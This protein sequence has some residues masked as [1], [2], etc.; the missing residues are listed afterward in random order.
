VALAV[1]AAEVRAEEVFVLQNGVVLR[2]RVARETEERVVIRLAGFAEENTVTVRKR[3][4][5]RRFTSRGT[6]SAAPA[7]PLPPL[8]SGY[9][10]P[11]SGGESWTAT[12]TP[13]P[14]SAPPAPPTPTVFDEPAPTAEP[15]L[16]SEGFF[17]RLKRVT[18]LALPKSFEGLLLV[19]FLVFVVLTVLVAGGTRAL[20]M[21]A[22]SLHA[23]S[24]LGLLLGIFLAADFLLHGEILRA[25]RALW[26][27]PLQAGVWL[28]VA[29]T[30]LDAPLSK[31]V[32][33]FA[34]VLFGSTCFMFFT[35]SVL[36][37]V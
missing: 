14:G 3:E 22:P 35:G 27:L 30:A 6:G 28:F 7:D 20:G 31:T 11:P 25:D 24:S 37:S 19:A 10:L 16:Q 17:E 23:S 13:G 21:K 18:G 8:P 36:V 2:G 15:S 33:L 26:I 1:L 29:R 34:F 9:P 5:R 32:P 12:G 4:I